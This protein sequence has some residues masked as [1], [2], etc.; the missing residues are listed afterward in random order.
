M[1]VLVSTA[2]KHGATTQIGEAIAT[3]LRAAGH[4]VDLRDPAEVRDLTGVDAVVLGSAVYAGRW[5]KPARELV[6]RM[7]PELAQ[8][9]VWLYSSGPVGN[10]PKPME[11]AVDVAGAVAKTGAVEHRVFA[12]QVDKAQ[13]SLAERGMVRAFRAAVGDFRDWEQIAAWAGE[14][15]THL[16]ATH[17]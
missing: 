16:R 14:I 13:L 15:D 8:R 17:S 3:G 1:K 9:P 2:S 6:D 5:L 4:D 11:D 7:G 12:G 10:P